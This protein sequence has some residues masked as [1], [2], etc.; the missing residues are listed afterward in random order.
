[1]T[2]SRESVVILGGFGPHVTIVN[3]ETN[4][5]TPF[6]AYHRF[7]MNNNVVVTSDNAEVMKLRKL[8]FIF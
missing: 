7:L 8:K 4:F 6:K 2:I 3:D 1:M 5:G